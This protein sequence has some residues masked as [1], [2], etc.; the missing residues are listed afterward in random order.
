MKKKTPDLERMCKFCEGASALHNPDQMLCQKKGVVSATYVCR[1]FQY[2]PL[3]RDPGKRAVA[4]FSALEDAI[5]PE[6]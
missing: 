2:D 5:S 6:E 4:D 1:A 3:K